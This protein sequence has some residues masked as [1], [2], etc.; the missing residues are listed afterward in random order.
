VD[1]LEAADT[2]F[3]LMAV[4]SKSRPRCLRVLRRILP[5]RVER[6]HVQIALDVLHYID[7][8]IVLIGIDGLMPMDA[9]TALKLTPA[10]YLRQVKVFSSFQGLN[11]FVSPWL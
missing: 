7:I 6:L 1:L 2:L 8:E 3:T 10:S 9:F 11:R 5:V 4:T